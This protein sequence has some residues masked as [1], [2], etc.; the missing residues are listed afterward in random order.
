[1]PARA[2]KSA[3]TP[4]PDPRSFPSLTAHPEVSSAGGT[5]WQVPLGMSHK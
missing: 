2:S 1:M 5:A 4:A 3:T